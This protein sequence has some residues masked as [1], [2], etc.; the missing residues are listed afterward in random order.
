MNG[1]V[2][3]YMFFIKDHL[4]SVRTVVSETGEVL[5]T[6]EFYP[7]GDL[8]STAG[9]AGSNG[10]RYRFTGKELGDETGLYDFSARY[11]QTSLG[12]F[13]TIDPLAEKSSSI[14]PYIYCNSNPV[15]RI[16]LDGRI[17]WKLTREGIF[18]TISGIGAIAGGSGLTAASGGFAAGV[19]GFMIANGIVSIGVGVSMITIGLTTDPSEKND[20]IME[21]LPSDTIN[22]VAKSVDHIMKNEN[23]EVENA[24][25][26]MTFAYDIMN[27]R[28]DKIRNVQDA[29]EATGNIFGISSYVWDMY[30]SFSESQATEES[31]KSQMH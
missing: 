26:S 4:G 8:L 3:V 31:N 12:R 16:D 30:D 24:V 5:Q 18:T 11:L 10:N 29:L 9:T 17:D 28:V 23:N 19:G 13:T 2:P 25:S 6:N 22:A 20:E 14:S 7:Y 21:N 27:L 1:D 15:N